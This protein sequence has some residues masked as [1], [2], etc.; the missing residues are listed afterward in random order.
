VQ[1]KTSLLIVDD[2]KD[3]LETMKD[4][5]QEKRYRIEIAKTGKEALTK[6]EKH[7]FD[8]ALIDIKL[9]DLSGLDVLR[10]FRDNHPK[11]MNIMITGHA[12]VQNAA[13][14]VNLGAH[15]YIMKPVDMEKLHNIIKENLKTQ[16]MDVSRCEVPA[17]LRKPQIMLILKAIKEG[18]VTE[19]KPLISYE[20]GIF[21][22]ELERIIPNPSMQ[23][24]ILVEFEKYGIMKR[25]FYNSALAC[26]SCDSL[27]I[28]IQFR[29]T[30][31]QSTNITRTSAANFKCDACNN[32]MSIPVHE[33]ICGGCGQS[34]TEDQID[35]KKFFTFVVETKDKALVDAWVTNFYELLR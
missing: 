12:T 14:A 27:R 19:F 25:K 16:Q 15:A 10:T 34:F 30:S 6:A 1:E 8:V 9:P 23:Y 22:P 29:C 17:S 20:R 18:K 26:P 13:D 31:C 3:M 32:I 33:Y 7:F 5:F 11:I 35:I 21:Y 4:C 28:S 24:S 2:D